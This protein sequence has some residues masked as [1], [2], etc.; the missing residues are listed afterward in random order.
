[1]GTAQATPLFSPG[2]QQIS[3]YITEAE[4]PFTLD[5]I[6]E[7]NSL[8]KRHYSSLTSE[9]KRRVERFIDGII[10]NLPE[11]ELAAQIY[12]VF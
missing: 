10:E 5:R 11:K 12:G 8:Y 6:R 4:Q 2:Y 9:E 3:G 7:F 1:M